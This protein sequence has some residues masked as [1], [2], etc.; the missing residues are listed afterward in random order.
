MVK[1][2]RRHNFL[3]A[4]HSFSGKEKKEFNDDI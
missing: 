1:P 2:P 3:G 4:G